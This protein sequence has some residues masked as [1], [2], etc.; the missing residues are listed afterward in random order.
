MYLCTNTKP[1]LL[2]VN[3][4]RLRKQK[5]AVGMKNKA[6]EKIW[7]LEEAYWAHIYQADYKPVLAMV[8]RK[9]LGW[10]NA[11]AKP[12]NKNGFVSFIEQ[13][14]LRPGSCVVKIERKG[15]TVL[16]KVAL[17]QSILHVIRSGNAATAPKRSSRRI[18]HTWVKEGKS[19]KLLGGMSCNP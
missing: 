8:H 10:P 19:W 5:R 2:K 12:I 16:G 1:P 15:I 9:F 7:L 18:T 3:R 11:T 6:E 14:L 17:T 13:A 4:V